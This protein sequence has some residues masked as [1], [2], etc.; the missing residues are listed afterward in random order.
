MAENTFLTA[1]E[2]AQELVRSRIEPD[3]TADL[4]SYLQEHKEEGIASFL[5]HFQGGDTAEPLQAAAANHLGD[6]E[7][8]DSALDILGWTVGF[9]RYYR[10]EGNRPQPS[11]RPSEPRRSRP[12]RRRPREQQ[13]ATVAIETLQEGQQLEGVVR[14]IMPYGVFVGVGAERD[15]LVHVSELQNSFTG[16]PADVVSVDET[17]QV[18]VK[19]ID[20]EKMRISLTMK[21]AEA[22]LAPEPERPQPQ[23]RQ[24]QQPTLQQQQRQERRSAP[25]RRSGPRERA[26]E[27]ARL[28]ADEEPKEMSALGEALRLALAKKEAGSE[29]SPEDS[30]QKK[31]DK[32]STELAEALR[33]TLYG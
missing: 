21:G 7:D 23:Q 22:A 30:R 18:W 11:Q 31:S 8:V 25:R 19:S 16:D 17:V 14:R 12:P 2:M 4:L 1:K 24:F 5:G 9:M 29:D 3:A 26:P 20:L 13:R 27:S 10:G 28:Y 6:L 15:G 32:Q 33:R